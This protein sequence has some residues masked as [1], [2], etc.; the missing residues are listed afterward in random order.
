MDALIAGFL[1]G[2]GVAAGLGPISLLCIS[3]G[4][5]NG[6]RPAIGVGLGAAIVDGLYALAA[7][8]GAAALIAGR[9]ADGLR[10]VG[11]LTLLVVAW[12]TWKAEASGRAAFERFGQAL[13]VSLFATLA[14]PSTIVYWAG[15]FAATVP[16]LHLSR[17]ATATVL[18]LGVFVGSLTWFT[19][20]STAAGTAGHHVSRHGVRAIARI[21]SL[22]IAGFGLWTI[23]QGLRG[24]F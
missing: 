23:G 5:K 7:G 11:G 2:M 19:G 3:S 1:L 24:L 14:N 8:L 21:G 10:V 18:P 17:A 12:H 15:T 20:L 16:A 13:R 6:F 22:A 9:T 4:L